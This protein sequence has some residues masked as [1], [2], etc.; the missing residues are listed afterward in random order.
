[1]LANCKIVR[2]NEQKIQVVKTPQGNESQTFNSL[3]KLPFNSVEQAL[4]DYK[5]VLNFTETDSPV[6]FQ[7]NNNI[8]STYKEALNQAQGRNIEVGVFDGKGEFKTIKTVSSN[9]NPNTKLGFINNAIKNNLIEDTNLVENGVSYL[10]GYGYSDE[11]TLASETVLDAFGKENSQYLEKH[12][13]GRISI[14]S[15]DK[16]E[17]TTYPNLV[18]KLGEDKAFIEST[19]RG[20]YEAIIG[21]QKLKPNFF[22]SEETLKQQI[23]DLLNKVGFQITSIDNYQAQY[24]LKNGELPNAEALIDLANQVV[25]FKNGEINI[26]TLSEEFVHFVTESLDLSDVMQEVVN[27]DEYSKYSETYRS[28]Y[29]QIEGLSEEEVENL[30]RKEIVDKIIAQELVGRAT[31]NPNIFQAVWQK[32]LDFFIGLNQNDFRNQISDLTDRVQDL[33][34]TQN[35]ESLQNLQTRRFRMYSVSQASTPSLDKEKKAVQALLRGLQQQERTLSN[36]G[37][38]TNA[39]KTLM[40]KVEKAYL[41]SDIVS[42]IDLATRQLRYVEQAIAKSNETREPLSAEERL[43]AS[44]LKS[45]ILPLVNRIAPFVTDKGVK[46]TLNDTTAR[47]SNL[48]ISIQEDVLDNLIDRVLSTG[49][50]PERIKINGS[51]VETRQYIK[52]ALIQADKDTN[53]FFAFL[54]QPKNAKD[55]ILNLLGSVLSDLHVNAQNRWF[56]E[57][58]TFANELE[59]LGLKPGDLSKF[60]DGEGWITS[61]FDWMK[62][63]QARKEIEVEMYSM[64]FD[65]SLEDAKIAVEN[66]ENSDNIEYNRQLNRAL[67]Q[68]KENLLTEKF[69]EDKDK[70]RLNLPPSVQNKLRQL[71]LDRSQIMRDVE[72]ENGIPNFTEQDKLNLE[73]LNLERKKASNPFST[74]TGNLKQGLEFAEE[75]ETGAVAS[76]GHFIKLGTVFSEEAEIAYYL[77]KA[78][79]DY[80]NEMKAKGVDINSGLDKNNVFINKLKKIEAEKGRQSAINY[81]KANVNFGFG[82]EVF[83]EPY[84]DIL[85]SYYVNET[86]AKLKKKYRDYKE[87][88]SKRKNILKQFQDPKNVT[89]ILANKMT[90]ETMETI[91]ELTRD[92]TN[93]RKALLKEK[94]IE[95][96]PFENELARSSVNEAYRGMLKDNDAET[97]LDKKLSLIMRHVNI[98]SIPGLYNLFQNLEMVAFADSIPAFTKKQLESALQG[99][100]GNS[101]VKF[102]DIKNLVKDRNTLSQMKI[103]LAEKRLAPYYRTFQPVSLIGLEQ[104]L[105]TSTKS[106]ADIVTALNN[107]SDVKLT[108]HQSYYEMNQEEYENKNFNKNFLAY[109]E[110]PK[111][112]D[113]DIEIKFT[114]VE[115]NQEVVKKT[116][117]L[118]YNFQ[119]KNFMF[120]ING[121]AEVDDYGVPTNVANPN[122]P[123]FKAYKLMMEYHYKNLSLQKEERRRNLYRAP[124]V[125]RTTLDRMKQASKGNFKVIREGVK[126]LFTFRADE[127]IQGQEDEEGNSIL[128]TTGVRVVPKRYLRDLEEQADVTDDLFYSVTLMRKEAELFVERQ[129]ALGTVMALEEKMLTRGRVDSKANEASNTSRMFKHFVDSNIFGNTEVQNFRV[130]LPILGTVDMAKVLKVFHRFLRFKNLAYKLSIPITS[131]ATAE[132]NLIMERYLGQYIDKGS[133]R[134][135]R[136]V[137]MKHSKDAITESLS[138]N[139]TSHISLIGEYLDSFNM[140]RSFENAKYGTFGRALGKSAMGLNTAGNYTPLATSFLAFT[141]GRRVY[142]GKFMSYNMF[143]DAYR[144][145]NPN[146]PS[147]DIDAQW[148]LME[149]KSFYSY[150]STANKKVEVDYDRMQADLGLSNLSKEEFKQE[151]KKI[152]SS[153]ITATKTFVERIDG[154]LSQEQSSIIKNHFLFQYT[155]THK[156]WLAISI[157]NRFK[158]G[159]LNFDAGMQEEG[160]YITLANKVKEAID[161]TFGAIKKKDLK[162]LK[163]QLMDLY[164][165]A[166]PT[167]RTNLRRLMKDFGIA[168]ALYVLMLGLR[169]FSDDEENQDLWALQYATYISERVLNE[170]KSSQFGLFGEMVKS[171]KE[172]I[173]GIES[174]Q[175]TLDVT[176]LWDTDEFKSGKYA[177]K[178]K[179]M[180]YLIDHLPGAK[181]VYTLRNGEAVGQT[182]RGYEFYNNPEDWNALAMFLT[183]DDVTGN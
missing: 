174:I 116:K 49:Q 9:T 76:G 167:E 72:Y 6:T 134:L 114:E 112:G 65:V 51:E 124:Q 142:G 47:I 162:G 50:F 154:A 42:A 177:G 35:P 71:D 104:E 70:S 131:W 55:P 93:E 41:R 86:D 52:D 178:T 137:L 57:T 79:Q 163:K 144:K 78:T 119:N 132:V 77:S 141:I 118:N 56:E 139:K 165:E 155:S 156:D 74:E 85:D 84:E 135:A 173:V 97:D 143:K 73:A 45:A 115:N 153:T 53:V 99:F 83:S 15:E 54:G 63:D 29:S 22:S 48:D 19:T 120:Q 101:D 157:Q 179:A 25:A 81:L 172:P 43:V 80:V 95:Q 176:T 152:Y 88:V 103:F 129:R 170:T 11:R 147:K 140:E 145:T 28:I 62:Y 90:P 169:M 3:A 46:E 171:I 30:V 31:S 44:N 20:V 4:E 27:T 127:Q 61:A 24:N 130:N 75:G 158:S 148:N 111:L 58:K 109:R 113:L 98:Q 38:N 5:Q 180:G 183:V 32:I 92:I 168:S 33:I 96:E 182:R 175:K 121:T 34:V 36:R 107:S 106:I 133:V 40:D 105:N 181:E 18:E 69:Y 136:K 12:V 2:N 14:V 23:L 108:L 66:R 67:R 160:S 59:A 146:V 68:I 100:N 37:A 159:H 82:D 128:A 138:V 94:N 122:D 164:V 16:I 161:L 8:F 13:D 87:L 166:T 126:D 91:R 10:R 21:R 150:L 151:Y 26:N 17:R 64:F 89:N 110:Q 39:I 7:T 125:S 60:Y 123:M 117:K 102:S 149:N 1:M